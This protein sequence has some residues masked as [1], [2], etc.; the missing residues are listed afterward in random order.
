MIGRDAAQILRASVIVS[1][2]EDS[3]ATL[4]RRL[5]SG[6]LKNRRAS[7]S[8]SLSEAKPFSRGDE[9]EQIAMFAVSAVSPFAAC[10]LAGE[11]AFEP[12]IEA[13]ARM[14][15]DVADDPVIAAST[16]VREIM[17][18]NGLDMFGEAARQSSGGAFHDIASAVQALTRVDGRDAEQRIEVEKFSHDFRGL[19]AERNEEP[20]LPGDDFRNETQRLQPFDK[21]CP[22]S[23]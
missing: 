5:E 8:V 1:R 17:L 19:I 18:A 21:A 10:A 16:A 9:I 6:R 14:I 12:H 11:R 22:R 20:Q 13:A 23:L 4:G 7:S 2:S 15:V 3:F